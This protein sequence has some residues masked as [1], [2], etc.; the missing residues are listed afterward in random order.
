MSEQKKELWQA[1]SKMQAEIQSIHRT[2]ANSLYNSK[3]ATLDNLLVEV[4]PIWSKH[5]LAVAQNLSTELIECKVPQAERD[6][7]TSSKK[8]TY[9]D[10]AMFGVAVTTI[11]ALGSESIEFQGLKVYTERMDAHGIASASTYARRISLMAVLGVSASDD[12]DGNAAATTAPRAKKIISN[13]Q[14]LEK[15]FDELGLNN[16]TIKS[17][18]KESGITGKKEAVIRRKAFKTTE[19]MIAH[20]TKVRAVAEKSKE[21]TLEEI[22]GDDK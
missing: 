8:T 2:Q 4:R 17:I 10:G 19:E 16:E 3:Y 22:M 1:F 13:T 18:L 20:L 5:G 9:V 11:V 12:D 7:K 6:F 15:E 14:E 21:P